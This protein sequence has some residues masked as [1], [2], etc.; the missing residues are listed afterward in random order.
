MSRSCHAPRIQPQRQR[1]L[2]KHRTARI[3][4]HGGRNQALSGRNQGKNMEDVINEEIIAVENALPG[5]LHPNAAIVW[6]DEDL[7]R[8]YQGALQSGLAILPVP[9]LV[10]HQPDLLGPAPAGA[11]V[12]GNISQSLMAVR[13][14]RQG[15]GPFNYRNVA[16]RSEL[17][18][19]LIDAATRLPRCA[20][21]DIRTIERTWSAAGCTP[22]RCGLFVGVPVAAV[23]RRA[24]NRQRSKRTRPASECVWGER[25]S[26]SERLQGRREAHRRKNV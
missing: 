2:R 15:P 1:V 23:S 16:V 13:R 25:P 18:T 10:D 8:T 20:R 4:N 14:S 11:A 19:A 26:L 7:G 3:R 5:E 17:A 24:Y 22:R 21:N 6:H 9:F 12:L